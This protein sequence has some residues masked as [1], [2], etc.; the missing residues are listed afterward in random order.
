MNF[1]QKIPSGDPSFLRV[2]HV[3]EDWNVVYAVKHRRVSIKA[4]LRRG[5]RSSYW[6]KLQSFSL[7]S[8]ISLQN[9][10]SWN[11]LW[12]VS[13]SFS[14][15]LRLSRVYPVVCASINTFHLTS[16]DTCFPRPFVCKRKIEL[17]QK[18]AWSDGKLKVVKRHH[19]ST[20]W[21]SL[22]GDPRNEDNQVRLCFNLQ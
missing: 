12:S 17:Y 8:L 3:V 5:T 16:P 14:H 20:R 13:I 9:C 11:L 19:R 2:R 22:G 21:P 7:L 15:T 1:A 10:L 18:G 4:E 6:G